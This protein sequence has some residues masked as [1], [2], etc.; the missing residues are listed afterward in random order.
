MS[1]DSLETGLGFMRDRLLSWSVGNIGP[2]TETG[3]S[4]V[5]L[6]DAEYFDAVVES[7]LVGPET[8]LFVQGGGDQ[9]HVRTFDCEGSIAEPGSEFAVGD[10]FFLQIQ[11]YVTTEFVPLLGPTLIRVT[12][13]DDFERFLADADT[14]YTDG[15]F[16]EF[17]VAPSV[18]IADLPGLG[19]DTGSGGPRSRLY[20]G[21]HGQVST[22]P[23]GRGLGT[24]GTSM[25]ELQ[26]RWT[27]L[28]AEYQ[29]GCSVCL[30]NAIDEDERTGALAARPWIARY[31][32]VLDAVRTLRAQNIQEIRVSGFGGGRLL[33]PLDE[34]ANPA[35]MTNPQIPVVMESGGTIYAYLPASG[36]VLRMPPSTG[37]VLEVLTVCGSVESAIEY[38]DPDSVRKLAS[39]L[40]WDELLSAPSR[41]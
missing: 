1:K 38:A 4:T 26:D 6:E 37:H 18:R 5:L 39:L 17:V 7:D 11:D 35:D 24:V 29:T 3:C 19:A 41:Q 32:T 22:S 40:Q 2:A 28:N 12:G 8:A 27:E 9:D 21:T 10:D 36:R 34:P 16:Q 15:S 13:A 23:T 14:A 20:V 30:S 33:S 31:L 25:A